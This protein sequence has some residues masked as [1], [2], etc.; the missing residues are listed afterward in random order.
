MQ[1]L[2]TFGRCYKKEKPTQIPPSIM[3]VAVV[4]VPGVRSPAGDQLFEEE[5]DMHALL[6][7]NA[8][9]KAPREV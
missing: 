5:G 8:I 6:N 3:G 7:R 2:V 9:R 1:K 4:A